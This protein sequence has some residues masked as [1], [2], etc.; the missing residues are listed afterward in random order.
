MSP[1][2]SEVA[3]PAIGGSDPVR[4]GKAVHGE[5][6]GAFETALVAGARE[7]FCSR[8]AQSGEE[9]RAA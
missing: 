5:A 1:V 4:L 9:Q 3:A 8:A 7:R 2:K 6:A